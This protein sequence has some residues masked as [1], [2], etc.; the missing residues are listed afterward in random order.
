MEQMRDLLR[1]LLGRSL[2]E[3]SPLDRIS[4]AWP[5]AAG[6]A[7]A[8]RSSVIALNGTVAIVEVADVAWLKQLRSMTP[9][10]R[11]ELGRVSTVPITDILFE[12]HRTFAADPGQVPPSPPQERPSSGTRPLKPRM[13]QKDRR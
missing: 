6:P 9:R 1:S 4:V 3:F 13:V 5:V 10:L 7:I 2:S 8:E 12:T 11:T